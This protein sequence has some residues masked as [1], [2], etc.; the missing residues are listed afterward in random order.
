MVMISFP[1]GLNVK[2]K[3]DGINKY[4]CLKTGGVTMTS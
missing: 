3:Y 4:P 2:S 1:S